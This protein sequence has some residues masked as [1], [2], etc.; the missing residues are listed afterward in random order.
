MQRGHRHIELV[1]AGVLQQQEFVLLAVHLHVHQ[2]LVAP[3]AV[4]Q[5][6]HRRAG[7][8]LA[9]GADAQLVAALLAGAPA[10]ALHHPLAVELAF[11][12]HQ[13]VVVGG[14]EAGVQLAA[15]ER[16]A[17]RLVDEMRPALLHHRLDADLLH[18]LQQRLAAAG[19]F[20]H[21]QNAGVRVGVGE[22]VQRRQRVARLGVGGHRGRHLHVEAYRLVG[23]L[24]A[25][26]GQGLPGAVE[27]IRAQ[28][29]VRRR[30]HRP[31]DVVAALLVTGADLVP[32][33][34]GGLFTAGHLHR[35]RLAGQ[36]VEQG[37]QTVE[38]QRQI[39]FQA[40]GGD[41]LGHVL[42]EW[43]LARVHVEG[44][45]E[46]GAEPADAL[47]AE[48]V[49]GGGQQIDLA[50]LA[51]GALGLRVEQ[52]Q[53]LDVLVKQLDPERLLRTHREDVHDGAAHRE[54][55]V[56][57]D[58]VALPVAAVHQ[59]RAGGLHI[60]GFAHP[61][62]ETVAADVQR[63]RDALHQ[64]VHRH[65]Q[66]A[67]AGAVQPVQ[68]PDAVADDVLVRAE[69]VV[70]QGLPVREQHHRHLAGGARVACQIEP[71]GIR[72]LLGAAAV[73]RGHQQGAVG[74]ARH[75]GE[76]GGQAAVGQALPV[77]VVVLTGGEQRG[78]G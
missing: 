31:A 70:G 27:L 6:H 33:V 73:R 61:Q 9:Q 41:A 62:H 25:R 50:D 60:E 3:D 32:E 22:G 17:V 49:L 39:V 51:G 35:P 68:H 10:A 53:R 26:P 54:F 4:V 55:A 71:Q 72:Q 40:R 34:P 1:A 38:K 30:Q 46:G 69:Q 63:R 66:H 8:D 74:G 42:I 44:V 56:L 14:V 20:R 43:H 45:A 19:G 64:G 18:H 5:V 21:H 52:A 29:Q 75:L 7:A 47:G 15:G 24:L 65:H 13:Q 57:V 78:I 48:R 28:E 16:P 12:D 23:I 76:H 11:G 36:V 59:P 67:G 2:A 37:G 77:F 58:V